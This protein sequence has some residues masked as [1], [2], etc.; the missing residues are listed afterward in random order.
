MKENCSIITIRWHPG[1]RPSVFF[2]GDFPD[3]SVIEAIEQ[4]WLKRIRDKAVD[5]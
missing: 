3:G 1:S 5:K 2:T 4:D